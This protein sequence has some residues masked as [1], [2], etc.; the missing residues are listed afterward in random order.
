MLE[1]IKVHAET[2]GKWVL[3]VDCVLSVDGADVFS[4]KDGNIKEQH[5]WG[6]KIVCGIVVLYDLTTA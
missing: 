4:L 5:V 1:R 3:V 2:D 6:V